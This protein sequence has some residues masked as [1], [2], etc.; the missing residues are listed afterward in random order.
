M[1]MESVRRYHLRLSKAFAW[2]DLG[3]SELWRELRAGQVVSDAAD[4]GLLESILAPV[5]RVEVPADPPQFK[6]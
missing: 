2:Y 1:M 5:E 6:R 4:V 3:R